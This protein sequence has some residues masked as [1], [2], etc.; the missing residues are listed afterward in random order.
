VD[1]IGDTFDDMRSAAMQGSSSLLGECQRTH[2][3]AI[4]TRLQ[5]LVS[6]GPLPGPDSAGWL[7]TGGMFGPTRP[8]LWLQPCPVL[9]DGFTTGPGISEPSQIQLSYHSAG[10]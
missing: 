10:V 9:S 1:R 5:Q 2:G 6:H 7:P 3:P 8:K 4:L